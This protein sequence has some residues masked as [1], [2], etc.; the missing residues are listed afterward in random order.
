MSNDENTQFAG[1]SPA[2][3]TSFPLENDELAEH[4]GPSP[5]LSNELGDLEFPKV[6]KHPLLRIKTS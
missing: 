4:I 2:I 5:N 1:S 6:I 3:R